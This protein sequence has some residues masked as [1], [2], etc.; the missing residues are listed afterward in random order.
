MTQ[1]NKTLLATYKYIASL[2]YSQMGGG[3]RYADHTERYNY[4]AKPLLPILG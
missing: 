2:L 4:F 3:V 1:D